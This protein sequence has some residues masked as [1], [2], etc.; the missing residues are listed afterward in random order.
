MYYDCVTTEYNV[1]NGAEQ[2]HRGMLHLS[3]GYLVPKG[4]ILV[5]VTVESAGFYWLIELELGCLLIFN[6]LFF[7]K[8]H[9]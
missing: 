8:T 6:Y 7:S 4:K 3:K 2:C 9:S 1:F 5:E